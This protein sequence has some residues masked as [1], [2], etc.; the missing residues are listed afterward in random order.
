MSAAQ[1][2]LGPGASPFNW[3]MSQL[4][5]AGRLGE[6]NFVNGLAEAIANPF[7]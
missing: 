6:V 4:F 1:Q 7:L 3:E 5:R 2:G